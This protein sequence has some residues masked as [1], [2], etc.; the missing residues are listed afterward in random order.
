MG[1]KLYPLL[2]EIISE[3]RRISLQTEIIKTET[4]LIYRLNKRD[5][6]YSFAMGIFFT[7]IFSFLVAQSSIYRFISIMLFIIAI[8]IFIFTKVSRKNERRYQ[9]NSAELRRVI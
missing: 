6:R 8:V 2:D 9:E 5:N 7:A 4:K 1:G 3:L